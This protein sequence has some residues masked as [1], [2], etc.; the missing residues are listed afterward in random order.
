MIITPIVIPKL[1]RAAGRGTV[2]KFWEREEI[3][4]KWDESTWAKRHEQ[5]VKRRSLTDFER[6]KVLRLKKQV[7]GILS[8]IILTIVIELRSGLEL[9]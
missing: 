6:F 4:K 2:L 1:P 7:G 9:K 8:W 5:R 3:E